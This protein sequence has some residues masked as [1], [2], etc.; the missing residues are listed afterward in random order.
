LPSPRGAQGLPPDTLP[1]L[2]LFNSSLS[3]IYKKAQTMEQDKKQIVHSEDVIEYYS[4]GSA[5][6]LMAN[7][8]TSDRV[9]YPGM[10]LLKSEGSHFDSITIISIT[11][12]NGFLY[13]KIK[14]NKTGRIGTI[15]Q[16]IDTDYYVWTLIS[17]DYL[18]GEFILNNLKRRTEIEFDF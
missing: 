12:K 5:R 11:D 14:D 3:S 17:Y 1:L 18:A 4:D 2:L 13:L 16:K 10:I 7:I 9:I 6:V 8:L 15:S